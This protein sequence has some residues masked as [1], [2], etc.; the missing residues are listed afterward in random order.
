MGR[1]LPLHG[2]EVIIEEACTFVRALLKLATS[3]A[4][5]ARWV[6]SDGHLLIVC[7]RPN[8]C[9][10]LSLPFPCVCEREGGENERDRKYGFCKS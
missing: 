2:V 5:Q 10:P 9:F 1:C 3:I 7:R 4:A 8:N 6:D